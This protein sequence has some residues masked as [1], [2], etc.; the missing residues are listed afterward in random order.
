MGIIQT[1]YLGTNKN[2]YSAPAGTTNI[3]NNVQ[4]IDGQVM[5]R[6][7]QNIMLG[8]GDS[9]RPGYTEYP[10]ASFQ[11]LKMF[12]YNNR[13]WVHLRD[14]SANNY[15]DFLAY[16]ELTTNVWHG[17]LVTGGANV[18]PNQ[19]DYLWAPQY[20]EARD[21]LI[22]SSSI[23]MLCSPK[24]PVNQDYSTGTGSGTVQTK[25]YP[26]GLPHSPPIYPTAISLVNTVPGLNS[27][28]LS[29]GS[30]CAYRYV[31]KKID[32]NGNVIY[33][34]P[35]QRIIFENT[36]GAGNPRATGLTIF[37]GP[38]LMTTYLSGDLSAAAR[39]SLEVYRTRQSTQDAAGTSAPDPGDDMYFVQELRPTTTD[40]TNGSVAFI[41]IASDSVLQ[42]PLYTNANQET[43]LGAIDRFPVSRTSA[44]FQNCAWAGNCTEDWVTSFYIGG[45]EDAAAATVSGLRSVDVLIV[46]DLCFPLSMV[47][48][49]IASQPARL[50]FGV[51]A[52]SGYY[53]N[54]ASFGSLSYYTPRFI[55]EPGDPSDF[56]GTMTLREI[57]PGTVRN[58]TRMFGEPVGAESKFTPYIGLYRFSGWSATAGS[59]PITPTPLVNGN[60]GKG[61]TINQVDYGLGV[62]DTKLTLNA[63]PDFV[64]G[65][66]INVAANVFPGSVPLQLIF[67]NVGI[68][69]VGQYVVKSIAGNVITV[70][71]AT[72]VTTLT[73][74]TA[75]VNTYTAA[76]GSFASYTILG[77]CMCV[78]Q[79]S[80][81]M[82]SKTVGQQVNN[83]HR[84][85][86]S[87]PNEPEGAPRHQWCD[88][89]SSDKD[90]IRLMPLGESLF[91]FKTDGLY[92]AQGYYPNFYSSQFDPNI[93]LLGP[94]LVAQM[95]GA[96]YALTTKGVFQITESSTKMISADIQDQIEY[97]TWRY[98]GPNRR[99]GF[100]ASNST[101][102]RVY[103]WLTTDS[104]NYD[105]MYD[106][107]YCFMYD[108]AGW[109]RRDDYAASAVGGMA[110]DIVGDQY[111]LYTYKTPGWLTSERKTASIFDYGDESFA[112]DLNAGAVPG[113]YR[114]TGPNTIRFEWFSDSVNPPWLGTGINASG[115]DVFNFVGAC[116]LDGEN[117]FVYW[118]TGYAS[119]ATGV[120]L[121]VGTTF[122]Y[123]PYDTS[124]IVTYSTQLTLVL[125]YSWEA[126]YG[127]YTDNPSI[128]Q[129]WT[130]VDYYFARPLFCVADMSASTDMVPG[131]GYS[132][133]ELNGFASSNVATFGYGWGVRGPDTGVLEEKV[134]K[135]VI[136]TAYQR[137]SSIRVGIRIRSAWQFGSLYGI[138]IRTGTGGTAIERTSQ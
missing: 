59:S 138:N 31:Y 57:A 136:Q 55:L 7:G 130:E 37:L 82:L 98:P 69:P 49:S 22:F 129:H 8:T 103:F 124:R 11:C 113:T 24:V 90:I 15:G 16:L 96:L 111:R 106:T 114:V 14:K 28:W 93:V 105:S 66:T 29:P 54:V 23:G 102:Q 61:F 135:G 137:G 123:P 75:G 40:F 133:A 63:A 71:D 9:K 79:A 65:D 94:E 70:K 56:V 2:R 35:S 78:K 58:K 68:V 43:I 64:V 74:S 107:R 83:R 104:T 26:A 87:N 12:F 92:R 39:W 108:G 121:T 119:D 80:T 30:K 116:I 89:G 125:P 100:A 42:N 131:T 77:A 44:F 120:T 33:G 115:L 72:G 6:R 52:I 32:V 118:V 85:Y 41:D 13:P 95:G 97:M 5:P 132:V 117:G 38:E 109:T 126:Q 27:N 73:N 20:V 84:A 127:V 18:K 4:I 47:D 86:F 19:D 45:I 67:G 101:D 48:T 36:L 17:S 53:S 88:F 50:T 110:T 51:Q 62:G 21:R 10:L 112:F 34:P 81:G 76:V 46:A 3:L 60:V 134:I 99:Y 122:P 91:V 128:R 25:L 1:K